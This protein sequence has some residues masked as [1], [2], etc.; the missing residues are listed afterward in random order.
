MPTNL[1]GREVSINDATN[2]R[3]S[4]R[5]ECNSAKAECLV[6]NDCNYKVTKAAIQ[7]GYIMAAEDT[8]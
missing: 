2:L 1:R 8:S 6:D 5:S 4:R 3:H 7:P